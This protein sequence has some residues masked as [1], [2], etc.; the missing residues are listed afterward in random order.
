MCVSFFFFFLL[1]FGFLLVLIQGQIASKQIRMQKKT[2]GNEEI[3]Q[4]NMQTKQEYD[5]RGV[6][7]KGLWFK[8]D[9]QYTKY[10]YD[11]MSVV[12]PLLSKRYHI[13]RT[14][15]HREK[16]CKNFIT[17]ANNDSIKLKLTKMNLTMRIW[18]IEYFGSQKRFPS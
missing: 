10:T 14:S 18:E 15:W 8:N 4:T 1:K 2:G 12:L 5:I 11:C 9:Q 13:K 6:V 3:L 16:F 7:L 17:E